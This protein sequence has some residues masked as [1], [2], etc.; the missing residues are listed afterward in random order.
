MIIK[1]VWK[2]GGQL[3]FFFAHLSRMM[4]NN[5]ASEVCKFLLFI[6]LSAHDL[7]IATMD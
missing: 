3:S 4:Q 7:K 5:Q 2:N 6:P 1:V